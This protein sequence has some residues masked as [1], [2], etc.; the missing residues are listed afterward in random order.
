[1][2]IAFIGQKGIPARSGGVEHHVDQLSRGLAVRSHRVSVYVRS[3]YTERTLRNY[4]GV[5]LVHLPTIKTKHLDASIHGFVSSLHCLFTKADIIHYQGIG[6]SFFSFIPKIFGCRVV[7]TVHRLDWA[8]EKWKWA[9]RVFLKAGEWMAGHV[10]H[11]TIAVSEALHR[12]FA[13]THHKET[14]YIPNGIQLSHARPLRILK[15]KYG[16]SERQFILYL[17]RLVPEK[18]PDWLIQ[19]FSELAANNDTFKALKLVIAGGSG[20]TDHYARGLRV[21]AAKNPRI[22]FTGT[23]WGE[24]KEELLSQA[25]MFVLP[26]YLEGN[27]IALLEAKSYG[28]CCLASDIGPHREMIQ[29]GRNGQLFRYAD[30]QDLKAKL[31]D[32]IG[33]PEEIQRLGKCGREDIKKRKTWDEVVER[34]LSVYQDILKPR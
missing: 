12:H 23:V 28:L 3:W 31:R 17:G 13:T 15:E 21:L 9:A 33:H 20:G 5:K 34:T 18:R 8:T 4:Q 27:P 11:R 16:L 10:P 19:A 32:L 2:K 1:M 14:I 6:P 25:L 22:I 24:E 29:P 26:S 30:R 7:A